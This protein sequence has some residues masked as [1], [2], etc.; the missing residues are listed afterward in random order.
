MGKYGKLRAMWYFNILRDLPAEES[1]RDSVDLSGV[2][3]PARICVR[4]SVCCTHEKRSGDSG[5]AIDLSNI[6]KP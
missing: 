4:C 3:E 1:S 6:C 2:G 5:S